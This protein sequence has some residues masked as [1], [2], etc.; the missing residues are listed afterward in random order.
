MEKKRRRLKLLLDILNNRSCIFVDKA[1]G[2]IIRLVIRL[3]SNGPVVFFLG[4][5]EAW[6][7]L[8]RK[9]LEKSVK[10][11]IQNRMDLP[12]PPLGEKY[13]EKRHSLG[14]LQQ[15]DYTTIICA[16]AKFHECE[17][18]RQLCTMLVIQ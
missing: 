1:T 3:Q 2:Q 13:R 5:L 16:K 7:I 14:S 11:D 10:W 9:I 15:F 12:P 6:E 17:S 4:G 18:K 8:K